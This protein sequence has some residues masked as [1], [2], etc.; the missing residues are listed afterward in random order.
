MPIGWL[1]S[2][3]VRRVQSV[4]M[5]TDMAAEQAV[6]W[7]HGPSGRLIG[8]LLAWP[9]TVEQGRMTAPGRPDVAPAVGSRGGDVAAA[10]QRRAAD[11]MQT[12]TAA[13]AGEPSRGS[14]M[15]RLL[16]G[17]PKPAVVRIPVVS[18]LLR[19]R[20]HAAVARSESI[21]GAPV[22]DSSPHRAEHV[23]AARQPG[24]SPEAQR[25][26]SAG[27]A[28]A[29]AVESSPRFTGRTDGPSVAGRAAESAALNT[30]SRLMPHVPQSGTTA[31]SERDML[32]RHALVRPSA[33]LPNAVLDIRG[34]L[35][36]PGES[37]VPMPPVRREVKYWIETIDQL[38]TDRL[39]QLE[40][41]QQHVEAA[42]QRM[43]PLPEPT[44]QTSRLYE[45]RRVYEQA[46]AQF[47]ERAFR[48]GR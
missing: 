36:S 24:F 45:A 5:P 32:I 17:A 18:W 12:G 23:V 43:Q 4:A 35:L 27:N 2:G 25:A 41:S 33:P 46:E 6:Q 48:L 39:T 44:S 21:R 11:E 10:P 40:R 38:I 15:Q 30:A 16:R 31:T 7:A 8:A 1:M 9:R 22:V 29:Q 14:G 37:P 20:L 47:Q 13:G 42:M 19:E 26:V 3:S 34:A 28:A